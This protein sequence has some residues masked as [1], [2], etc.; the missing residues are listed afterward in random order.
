Q[1]DAGAQTSSIQKFESGGWVFD[2]SRSQSEAGPVVNGM[3]LYLFA[4]NFGGTAD[5][6][7]AARVYS[8]KLWQK[9]GNGDYQ[10][11]RDF[12]PAK[13]IYDE[14]ALWDRVSETWFRN[15]GTGALSHGAER[16]WEDGVVIRFW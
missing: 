5:S 3:P 8:L 13:T 9:D 4:R 6:F 1:L 10:L 14:V 7:C 2:A 15:C 12:V 11:V 16:P